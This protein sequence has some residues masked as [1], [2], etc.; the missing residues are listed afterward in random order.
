MNS[1]SSFILA[2]LVIIGLI[3]SP[4]MSSINADSHVILSPKKQMESGVEPDDVVCKSGLVLMIRSTNGAAA[5]VKSTTSTI[6]ST[7]GWGNVIETEME[8]ELEDA[9]EEDEN[10]KEIILE[11]ELSMGEEDQMGEN[12][13]IIELEEGISAG[14]DDS[15]SEESTEDIFSIGG[16]DLSMAAPVEGDVD[17]PITII[18]FGDYQCPKCKQWFQQ[19]KPTITSKHIATGTVNLYF[20]DITWLGDDSIIAA[21]ASHCAEDQEKFKEYHSA[22]Y[23]N[24]AGIQE[25]WANSNSLK[26]F[27]IDLGLDSELFDECLDSGKYSDRVSYNTEVAISNDV[28]G[29]PHFFIIGP[30]GTT[31]MFSGALPS[32]AF[33]AAI[34]SLGY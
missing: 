22:L 5:C 26:Q 7:A 18:E 19:E 21:Q 9:M 28:S 25:G 15:M 1:T 14:E 30:D 8:D 13:T 31:K 20:V 33:D 12:Q 11:E 10:E 17:A 27:A 4:S 34:L 29:T 23:N 16:I 32:A 24:Q 3:L 2:S 6:L